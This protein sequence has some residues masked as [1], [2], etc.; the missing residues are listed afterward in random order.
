MKK[1]GVIRSLVAAA[2][3]A[4]YTGAAVADTIDEVEQNSPIAAA[5]ALVFDIGGVARVNAF[6]GNG[7]ADVFSFQAKEGDVVTVDIDA[8]V[9]GRRRYVRHGAPARVAGLPGDARQR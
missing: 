7:D 2:V 6:M 9:K 5:Q 4:A 3:I 1:V 8:A